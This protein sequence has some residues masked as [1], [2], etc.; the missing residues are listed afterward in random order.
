MSTPQP[1]AT[2][3]AVLSGAAG[4]GA[5]AAV[6]AVTTTATSSA[7]APDDTDDGAAAGATVIA[8]VRPGS[9]DE[10]TLFSG[11]REVVITDRALVRA[12]VNGIR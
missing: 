6:A 3:R 2:R 8:H 12:L 4:L 7:A 1:G 9:R 11:D 5:V 10:V